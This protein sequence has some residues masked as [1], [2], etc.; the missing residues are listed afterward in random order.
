MPPPKLAGALAEAAPLPPVQSIPAASGPPKCPVPDWAVEPPAGSRLLVYKDGQVIQEAP[1]AKIV[2]VFGRVDALADVVLDHPSISRQ[3]ATAAFHGAR[4]TWL[5]TDMG[6]T[7][8]TFVGGRQLAKAEDA[9]R[10]S[11]GD[12]KAG[13][14]AAAPA[15]AASRPRQ[16]ETVIGFSDGRDFVARVGPRAAAPAEGRFA[17]AV[18]S[19]IVVSVSP[20]G[21]P[22]SSSSLASPLPAAGALH[23]TG[24]GAGES[25]G[26]GGECSGGGSPRPL[27][28]AGRHGTA[29]GHGSGGA[30]EVRPH[31]RELVE[32]I[33]KETPRGGGGSLYEQLPP[34]SK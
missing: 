31:L 20:R 9:G 17:G 22:P 21:P 12:G 14:A 13:T 18:A 30:A 4:G 27:A 6:S 11:S 34:P 1:L 5:V 26:G 15:A 29:G 8:G 32:R 28:S 16:L 33:R 2:T 24:C 23:A 25:G 7:H 10:G 3:H 19:T